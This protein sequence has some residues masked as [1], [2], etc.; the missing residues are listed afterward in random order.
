MAVEETLLIRKDCGHGSI[1]RQWTVGKQV[2]IAVALALVL[3]S[4]SQSRAVDIAVECEVKV[5]VWENSVALEEVVGSS[6]GCRCFEAEAVVDIAVLEVVAER[7]EKRVMEEAEELTMVMEN[8]SVVGV[9]EEGIQLPERLL[10]F[11]RQVET[12]AT[13]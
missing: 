13:V 8:C 3:Q 6:E 7:I 12:L 2:C 9:E 4:N 10:V 11:E 1:V 5:V